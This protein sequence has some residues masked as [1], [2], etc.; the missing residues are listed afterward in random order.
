MY[1][2]DFENKIEFGRGSFGKVYKVLDKKW[3]KWVAMKVVSNFDSPDAEIN[4]LTQCR[5]PFIVQFVEKIDSKYCPQGSTSI[6]MEYCPQG[7]L[8]DI[9]NR[10]KSGFSE[11][12]IREIMRDVLQGLDYLHSKNIL[13][14]DIKPHNILFGT[15]GHYKLT[16][17]GESKSIDL[18]V[19]GTYCGT[20]LFMSPEIC[21]ASVKQYN[22]KCDIYSTGITAMYLAVFTNNFK[23]YQDL[24]SAMNK[25]KTSKNFNSDLNKIFKDSSASYSDAFMKFIKRCTVI[26]PLDRYSAKQLLIDDEF[27]NLKLEKSESG[28]SDRFSNEYKYHNGDHKGYDDN[29]DEEKRASRRNNK[30]NIKCNNQNLSHELHLESK[31]WQKTRNVFG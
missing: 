16:D 6:I 26:V 12:S 4:L 17:F 8:Q 11:L 29:D 3:N 25:L 23:T 31:N 24:I 13:H 2:Y 9:L 21:D 19:A 15:D 27:I 20:E 28:N 18:T 10:K 14:R 30:I 1:T 22:A 5:S 7:S